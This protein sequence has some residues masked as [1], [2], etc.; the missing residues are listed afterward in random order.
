MGDAEGQPEVEGT[1][2]QCL[3]HGEIHNALA[4]NIILSS[5]ECIKRR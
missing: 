4:S 2:K 3:T 5:D 1:E